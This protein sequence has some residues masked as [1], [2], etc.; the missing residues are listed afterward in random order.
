[1]GR[2]VKIL[3]LLL[4]LSSTINL[5]HLWA[6]W[7]SRGVASRL[8]EPRERNIQPGDT[9]RGI[10]ARG[11][12]GA[13]DIQFAGANLPT[14]VYFHASGCKWCDRNQASIRNLIQQVNKRYQVV[15]VAPAGAE[16]Q[17]PGVAE[18]TLSVDPETLRRLGLRS[19]PTTLAV[20]NT[21]Q[22]LEAWRGIFGRKNK[23]QVEWHFGVSL[24]EIPLSEDPEVPRSHR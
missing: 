10:Q 17:I 7:S 24:P 1:M 16:V 5:W 21:G 12:G 3:A 4:G 18:R 22:V 20:A 9:L 6:A 8:K 19:T 13:V 14:L 15:L 2:Q 23:D 11:P